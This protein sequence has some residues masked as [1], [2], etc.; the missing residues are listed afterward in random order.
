MSTAVLQVS[1]FQRSVMNINPSLRHDLQEIVKNI[2]AL[3]A[4]TQQDGKF[5]THKSQRALLA[6]LNPHDLAAVTRAIAEAEQS[7]VSQ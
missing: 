4:F 3:R 6:G 2:L 1:H 5:C 7:V